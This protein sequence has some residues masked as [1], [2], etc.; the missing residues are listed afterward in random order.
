M[1]ARRGP[2]QSLR[3][4]VKHRI[5]VR[6]ACCLG[7]SI[8]HR[9]DVH[10]RVRS[11]GGTKAGLNHGPP[12]SAITK[13]QAGNPSGQDRPSS[14]KNDEAVDGHGAPRGG[15]G[16]RR[17][18]RTAAGS[19]G[20]PMTF[21]AQPRWVHGPDWTSAPRDPRS[22]LPITYCTRINGSLHPLTRF[23]SEHKR[24]KLLSRLS[25]SDLTRNH[26][27]NGAHRTTN[28]S[29]DPGRHR[30]SVLSRRR[31]PGHNY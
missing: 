3:R 9:V 7:Q 31:W 1:T 22:P 20:M 11:R 18:V 16:E 4:Y 23:N 19:G 14:I 15:G 30:V 13:V 29:G 25:V 10:E 27:F 17:K 5:H 21:L 12:I 28:T 26:R 24:P 8:V 6:N 2:V